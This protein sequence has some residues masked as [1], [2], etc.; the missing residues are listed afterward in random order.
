MQN[1]KPA[2]RVDVA[3]IAGVSV[4][5]VSQVLNNTPGTRVSDK[6][7]QR[8][9]A[10][11]EE[12]GYSPSAAARS[13]RLGRNNVA[14]VLLCNAVN[15]FN[16]Y[17]AGLLKGIWSKLQD[18]NLRMC[19]DSLNDSRTDA[20]R[21]FREKTADGVII[22]A[23][24]TNIKNIEVMVKSG[25]PVVCVGDEAPV[26]TDYVDIDNYA[27]SYNAVKY[28]IE[29]GHRRIAHIKGPREYSCAEIRFNGYRAALNDH[30]IQFDQRL[31]V[32]TEFNLNIAPRGASE[33]LKRSAHFTAIFCASDEIAI[34][35]IAELARHSIKVPEQVSVIGFNGFL[36][37]FTKYH[38]TTIRQPL[39]K[40]GM[41]AASL[42]IARM[43]GE[44]GPA[45][46]ILN[47]G[48]LLQGQTTA[49]PPAE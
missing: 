25:Y 27:M 6:V 7:R 39:E 42:L 12:L 15:F 22:I 11:V 1:Y 30:G 28:L 16:D 29:L 19:L 31:V 13:L 47:N 26:H 24:R 38:I 35:V 10:A 32:D 48:D 8:I 43:N 20:S 3:R 2:R 23:P 36:D 40:I 9:L 17:T 34:G 46:T 37:T 49:A 14:G 21:F 4:G 41:D 5:A 33:L 44:S 18:N 45:R